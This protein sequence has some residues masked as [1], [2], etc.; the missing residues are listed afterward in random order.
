MHQAYLVL[1]NAKQFPI[2]A[3]VGRQELSYGD[4]RLVGAFDWNNIGRV[5]DAAKLRY[6]N[7]TLWVDA[8]TES[9]GAG[10]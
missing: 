10:K 7:D 3:K 4:E 5:F 9:R 6:E 2:S 1:G 8:F